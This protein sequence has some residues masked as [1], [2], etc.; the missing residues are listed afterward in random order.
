MWV[1]QACHSGVTCEALKSCCWRFGRVSA[2]ST[3]TRAEKGMS[4]TYRSEIDPAM[5]P[6][7]FVLVLEEPVAV[8]LYSRAAVSLRANEAAERKLTRLDRRSDRPSCHRCS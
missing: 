1:S 6:E 5:T 4:Q 8:S 7:S 3:R 2:S